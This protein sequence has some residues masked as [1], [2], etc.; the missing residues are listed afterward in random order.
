MVLARELLNPVVAH[1]GDRRVDL[2]G[3]AASIGKPLQGLPTQVTVT[4]R[5]RRDA[6]L[7]QPGPPPTGR[8]G[9]PRAKGDRLPQL[10]VPAGMTPKHERTAAVVGATGIEPVTSAV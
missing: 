4:A 7:S 10:I 8:R 5:L 9:R 3:D 1:L 6:A 2:I